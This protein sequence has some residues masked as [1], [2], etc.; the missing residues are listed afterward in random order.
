VILC[1]MAAQV[2]RHEPV[3]RLETFPRGG[4]FR[5]GESLRER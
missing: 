4:L 5:K 2:R 1:G 3:P